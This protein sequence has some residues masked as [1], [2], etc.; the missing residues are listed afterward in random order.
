MKNQLLKNIYY[1]YEIAQAE[2]AT[3]DLSR[4]LSA[5]GCAADWA[6]LRRQVEEFYT[7][8]HSG[9]FGG[10]ITLGDGYFI[11]GFMRHVRPRHMVEFGVASGFSSAFIVDMATKLG[12]ADAAPGPFLSTGCGI[13]GCRWKPPRST[14]CAT[15]TATGPMGR[16]RCSPS[17]MA[18]TRIPGRWWISWRCAAACRTAPGSPSRTTR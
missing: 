13:G 14:C 4:W 6:A 17:S 16:G 12:L 18:A 9:I 5:Q 1:G 7:R 3:Q 15:T 8:Q 11:A 10:Q 2:A